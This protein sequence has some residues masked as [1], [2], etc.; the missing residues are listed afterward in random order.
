MDVD[1]GLEGEEGVDVIEVEQGLKWS[2][3]R[4]KRSR[5]DQSSLVTSTQMERTRMRLS[6]PR[7]LPGALLARQSGDGF[8]A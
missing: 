2:V 7:K 1:L 5:G 8:Q 3:G 6:N 4:K